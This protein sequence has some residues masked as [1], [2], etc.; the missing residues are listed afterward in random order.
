MPGEF[1]EHRS[2]TDYNPCVC[3]EW[4]TTEQL[5]LSWIR[6]VNIVK[7][8]VHSNLVDKFNAVPIKVYACFYVEINKSIP[9]RIWNYK[10]SR[11]AKA[12]LKMKNKVGRLRLLDFKIYYKAIL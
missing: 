11:R 10:V 3:K 6:R 1:H 12:I 7:M 2:L 5:T 4:D 8:T 9:K